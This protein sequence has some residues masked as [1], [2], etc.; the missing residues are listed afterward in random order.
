ML[1]RVTHDAGIRV[2]SDE[3][4]GPLVPPGP[5]FTAYLTVPGSDNAI[6]SSSASKSWNLAGLK[7]SLAIAGPD[8]APDLRS[9]PAKIDYAPGHLGVLSHT[10]AFQDGTEW[11]DDLIAGLAANRTL[12]GELR[13]TH[14][15]QVSWTPPEGT[16]LAWLDCSRLGVDR[17]TTTRTPTTALAVATDIDGPARQRQQCKPKV[18]AGRPGIKQAWTTPWNQQTVKCPPIEQ[19][20]RRKSFTACGARHHPPRS[21]QSSCL[22]HG[23]VPST[24]NPRSNLGSLSLQTSL[25][26][27]KFSHLKVTTSATPLTGNSHPRWMG[28]PSIRMGRWTATRVLNSCFLDDS[29]VPFRYS[30]M[31]RVSS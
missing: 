20:H 12:L 8:A 23:P 25:T 16:Y 29:P 31:S 1:A 7:A 4:H 10:A 14:L 24:E 26:D 6:A 5:T 27:T 19:H 22:G 28:M 3:I 11:L 30:F 2:L 21:V 17:S 13:R 9:V 18:N 15:P